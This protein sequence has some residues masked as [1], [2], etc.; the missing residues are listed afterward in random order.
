MSKITSGLLKNQ[1]MSAPESS[2]DSRVKHG[3]G[4]MVAVG[5]K[6]RHVQGFVVIPMMTFKI[7]PAPTPGATVRAFDPSDLLGECGSVPRRPGPIASGPV[8]IE[9]D[10]EVSL[11]T[12]KLGGRTL[13]ACLFHVR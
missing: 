7:S 10:F 4:D 13:A 3:V 2:R 1:S 5:T 12:S 8:V 11:K 6:E 9:G